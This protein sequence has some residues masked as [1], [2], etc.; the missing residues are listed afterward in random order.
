MLLTWRTA[1]DRSAPAALKPAETAPA[2]VVDL[3]DDATPEDVARL[4]RRAAWTGGEQPGVACRPP[5]ARRGRPQKREAALAAL[6][7]DPAV[8]AAEP[9]VM[10]QLTPEESNPVPEAM[11]DLPA[12]GRHVRG[13][14]TP[15]DP[16]FR[17]QWNFRQIG[18]EKAWD[19]TRGKGA[20]SPSSIRGSHL[21]RTTRAA[22]RRRTSRG[23]ASC[24]ATISSTTTSTE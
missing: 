16:R 14:W 4:N 8:E 7:A 22:I 9:E 23:P 15:N 6:R 1:P 3:K 5:D 2:V 21:R 12:P 19:V 17:E 18:I 10:F 11:S 24:L 20:W 13:Y